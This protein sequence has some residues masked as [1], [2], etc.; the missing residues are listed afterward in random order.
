MFCLGASI[1]EAFICANLRTLETKIMAQR[2]DI[3]G[4]HHEVH[5]KDIETF[6]R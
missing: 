1:L 5:G 6:K 4:K 2:M 3:L